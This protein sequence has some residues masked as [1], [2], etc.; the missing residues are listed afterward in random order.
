[1]DED[2]NYYI[3]SPENIL[4]PNYVALL[5]AVNVSG[6][7][8]LKMKELAANMAVMGAQGVQTYIQS[9]NLVF[10]H[11]SSDVQELKLAME[12][13][14]L[15]KHQV[16]TVVMIFT[17]EKFCKISTS[18]PYLNNQEIDEKQLGVVFLEERPD[19][20]AIELLKRSDFEN[21]SFEIHD[22]HIYL[23]CRRGFGR[24]VVTNNFLEK[25]LG[26]KATTRNARTVRTLSGFVR[27]EPG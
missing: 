11:K 4:M 2:I 7:N 6:K 5:R 20:G 3:N 19:S 18:N 15:D 9:G 13:L 10:R 8:R 27:A 24:A 17:A 1:M 26:V 16:S 23:H 21:E 14:I 22:T 12:Q 25:R